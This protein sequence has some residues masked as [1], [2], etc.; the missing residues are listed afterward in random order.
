MR[1]EKYVWVKS[2]TRGKNNVLVLF[3]RG[4]GGGVVDGAQL[5]MRKR[6]RTSFTG[7]YCLIAT[8]AAIG[9]RSQNWGLKEIL[10]LL[11]Q[12][13]GGGCETKG[14]AESTKGP[15]G[16]PQTSRGSVRP[17]CVGKAAARRQVT[18]SAELSSLRYS[19]A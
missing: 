11:R 13:G 17:G 14:A 4:E 19:C 2:N 3:S 8:I 5:G 18:A 6:Q 15:P 1:P 7:C 10:M 12:V 9:C 16:I